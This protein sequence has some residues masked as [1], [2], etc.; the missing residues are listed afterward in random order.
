VQIRRYHTLLAL[1]ELR[2]SGE[3]SKADIARA[4]DLNNS[5][6]GQIMR[7]LEQDGLVEVFGK[8]HDGMRG[9]PATLYRLKPDGAFAIGVKLDRF[10]IETALI[11]FNGRML[12][13]TTHDGMLPKPD[14]ALRIVTDDVAGLLRSAGLE[15]DPR[16]TGIGLAQPFNLEAWLTELGLPRVTFSAWNDVNFT[17]MLGEA[18]G[19]QVFFENDGTAA[20]I[21]ELFYGIGRTTPDFL[22]VFIGP[23][24]GG[25]IVMNNDYLRGTSGNAGDIAVIPVPPSRLESAPKPKAEFDILLTRASL[26]GLYRHLAYRNAPAASR[27]ELEQRVKAAHPAYLE[28]LSDSIAALSPAIR[29]AAALLD[30]PNVCIDADIDSGLINAVMDGLRADFAQ[31]APEARKPP[32]LLHGTFGTNAGAIGVA[33]LP[34][35]F[36]YAPRTTLLTG[37]TEQSES[38]SPALH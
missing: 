1:R 5:S 16:V 13:R 24:I 19:M 15:N 8:R 3:A 17:Q 14:E 30:M 6:T 7:E 4:L 35:F 9:Q 10:G 26:A 27:E 22:Y 34:L 28:W 21:A 36:S 32:N 23:A 31:S 25:G 29:S 2:R 12:G 20:A 18:T 38:F 37:A 11:D 33:T